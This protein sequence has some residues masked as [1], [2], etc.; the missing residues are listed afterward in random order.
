MRR[1]AVLAGACATCLGLRHATAR[2]A[3]PSHALALI[4]PFTP[5]SSVGINARLLQPYLERALGQMIELQFVQGAGG[6]TGHLLGSEAAP[7]GYTMTMVSSSLTAQPWLNRISVAMPADF[8]FVG[9]VTSVP[10]VLLVRAGSPWHTLADLVAA[11]RA[12]PETLTTGTLVGWWPPALALAL[13]RTRAAIKPH[14]VSSY[15]SG[16]ELVE[17]LS[18]GQLDFVVAGLA[19][20]APSLQGGA[21]RALAVS[22]R[23]RALPETRTFSELGW[24]V[25]TAWWRGLAVP[26]ETPSEVVYRL[27]AGL[28]VALA[29]ADL[30]AEFARNGLSV[31]PLDGPEF[32]KLVLEEYQT[33]GALF[34]SLGLNLRVAKPM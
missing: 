5:G 25:T 15:Y 6:I 27:R 21:L 18:Q 16:A 30:L 33:F 31:D 24:D 3:F 10:S 34:T 8:T 22:G 29:S 28:Q 32:S 2:P 4:V 23:T 7:D 13:F 11:L 14:V 12:A 20:V 17:A 19:D 9:Q 1:R 26:A